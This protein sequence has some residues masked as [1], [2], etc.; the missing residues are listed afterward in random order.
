VFSVAYYQ[1]VLPIYLHFYS[2]KFSGARR[3][4]TYELVVAS[5]VMFRMI[6]SYP[7]ESEGL[8]FYWHWFVCLSVCLLP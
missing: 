2:M 1:M 3:A 6:Y 8:C 4:I 5:H 7:R